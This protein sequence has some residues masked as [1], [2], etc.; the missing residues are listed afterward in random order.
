MAAKH[1]ALTCAWARLKVI[2]ELHVDK[3]ARQ[4]QVHLFANAGGSR[5]LAGGHE[6]LA[7]AWARSG[8]NSELHVHKVA[9]P[10]R[11]QVT[12]GSRTA[13]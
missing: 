5:A 10:A 3:V 2:S 6:R 8:V 1:E 11:M 13:A 12:N 7:C 4:A 9:T